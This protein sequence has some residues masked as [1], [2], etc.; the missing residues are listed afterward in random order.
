MDLNGPMFFGPVCMDYMWGGRRMAEKYG[1][2]LSSGN[3]AESWEITD[4]PEGMS[5]VAL[6]SL[7]G[8]T[9]RQLMEAEGARLA[10]TAWAGRC[11]PLLIKI[12][13]ARERL[14]LQVHP[15][16]RDT[17]GEPKTEMWY[18]LD[19]V[20]GARV[21][22]G[23]KKGVGQ[24]ELTDAL[25]A[26][27][28]ED[29]LNAVP[30]SRGDAIFVPGGLLH[31]ID[32]GCL[33]L[34]VQQNSNTTYRVHDWGRVDHDGKPR[35]LHV[36]QAMRVIDW[37]CGPA[38]TIS[39]GRVE[40]CGD[41]RVL[42]IVECLHFCVEVVDLVSPLIEKPDKRSFRAYFVEDGYVD[43]GVGADTRRALAGTSF[44]MAAAA[45]KDCLIAPAHGGARLV[46]T[47]IP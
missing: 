11:F 47:R 2:N 46:R 38:G 10:G 19:A 39:V 40:R 17:V 30:V 34:E 44:L 25:V 8:T 29:V 23:L 41:N 36:E 37:S 18:V 43:V 4:R 45:E 31:A 5:R 35:E 33:I 6:G 16:D 7:A 32:E 24:K 21:F 20:P 22:A 42:T 13:D 12:I 3:C 9:L 15:R 1:R 26:N 27:T 14:S 28:V